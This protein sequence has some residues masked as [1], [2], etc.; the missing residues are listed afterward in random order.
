[1]TEYILRIEPCF[2]TE[3][4]CPDFSYNVVLNGE[5]IGGRKDK[6]GATL[7]AYGVQATIKAL[8]GFSVIIENAKD[9]PQ[10][11]IG[12]YGVLAQLVNGSR[13]LVDWFQDLYEALGEAE[14]WRVSTVI[15]RVPTRRLL[16]GRVELD[17]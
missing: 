16:S 13:E 3:C 5:V 10:P 1:L 4:G 2:K 7:I 6:S 9:I 17:W 12:D 15:M 14:K 11:T 8:T